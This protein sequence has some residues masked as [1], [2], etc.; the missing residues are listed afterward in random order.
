MLCAPALAA[1]INS[2]HQDL[3][4]HTLDPAVAAVALRLARAAA[5]ASLA[6]AGAVQTAQDFRQ[7]TKDV[8]HAATPAALN[9]RPSHHF[10]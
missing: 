9:I 10:E 5:A 1:A 8:P 4:G 2:D 3:F 7:R 6:G